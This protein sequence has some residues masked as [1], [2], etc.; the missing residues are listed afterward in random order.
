MRLTQR[1]GL[2]SSFA[3]LVDLVDIVVKCVFCLIANGESASQTVWEDEDFVAFLDINPIRQGHTLLIPKKH[4]EYVFDLPEPL[5]SKL[6]QTAK[7][8]AETVKRASNAKRVGISIEGFSVPHVCLHLVPINKEHELI[9]NRSN[10][11]D[12]N[13]SG[14]IIK[15]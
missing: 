4:F 1:E 10:V 11:L 6:F 15:R 12:L 5:Y 2:Y 8:V 3:L 14:A 7:R 13:L 9:P